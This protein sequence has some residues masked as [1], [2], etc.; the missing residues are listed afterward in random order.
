MTRSR[1]PKRTAISALMP[2]I[3]GKKFT[4]R[5]TIPGW[6]MAI[7]SIP[8]LAGWRRQDCG[9]MAPACISDLVLGWDR[10]GDTAGV[11][12][13]GASIGTTVACTSAADR[14][15]GTAPH[16][17]TAITTIAA[18]RDLHGPFRT[19]ADIR[20]A[21]PSRATVPNH[22]TRRVFVLAPSGDTTMAVIRETTLLAARA[23]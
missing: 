10:G 21:M 1:S 4:S 18:I 20:A 8:G 14:T 5:L 9:W 12:L 16:F 13:G 3:P 2:A 6:L 23:A 19:I 15:L 7:L 22:T 11:G 17:S